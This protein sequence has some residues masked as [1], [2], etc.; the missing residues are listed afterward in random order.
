MAISMEA[1]RVMDGKKRKRHANEVPTDRISVFL[2]S[3]AMWSAQRKMVGRLETCDRST[4]LK[5][6]F[7]SLTM[8]NNRT[9]GDHGHIGV[10]DVGTDKAIPIQSSWTNHNDGIRGKRAP[11]AAPLNKKCTWAQEKFN[12]VRFGEMLNESV[13]TIQSGV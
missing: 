3:V 7:P 11:S 4:R 12:Q 8:S 2:K 6:N 10:T 9:A 1:F 13:D 5:S